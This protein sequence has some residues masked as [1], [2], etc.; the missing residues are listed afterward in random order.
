MADRKQGLGP[1]ASREELLSERQARIGYNVALNYNKEPLLIVRGQA[2]YLYDEVGVE[3]C[4]LRTGRP[5]AHEKS[6]PK[7]FLSCVVALLS[8][9]LTT[10]A[11][12]RDRSMTMSTWTV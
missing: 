1:F 8:P 2:Q 7:S 11:P 4:A 3:W 10:R 5:R 6:H 9:S 12:E